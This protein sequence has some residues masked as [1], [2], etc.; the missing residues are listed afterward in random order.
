LLVDAMKNEELVRQIVR[1]FYPHLEIDS[2]LIHQDFKHFHTSWIHLV[3]YHLR[4][5]FR[6]YRTVANSS[7]VAFRMLK[8]I[9]SDVLERATDFAN[10][11]DVEIDSAF[12]YSIDVVR[13]DNNWSSVAA[14]HVMHYIHLGRRDRARETLEMYRRLGLGNEGEFSRVCSRLEG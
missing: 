10:L 4:E 1:S 8:S 2:L 13:G 11:S 5:Y 9:P 14:A 12:G 7:T 3:Q 6:L